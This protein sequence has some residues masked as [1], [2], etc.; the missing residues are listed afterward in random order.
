MVAL[1]QVVAWQRV[2][3]L[4]PVGPLVWVGPAW[5]PVGALQV[6]TPVGLPRV[7]RVLLVWVG[8]LGQVVRTWQPVGPLPL[9]GA[10]QP[11]GPA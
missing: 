5:Q 4:L 8:P 6:L 7:V 1:G 11:V 9:A 10:L 2:G 3:R